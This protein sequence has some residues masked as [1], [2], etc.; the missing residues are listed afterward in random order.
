[1]ALCSSPVLYAYL[2]CSN[3]DFV[4]R[5]VTL[6][7]T[8]IDALRMCR[9]TITLLD[10]LRKRSA[11]TCRRVYASRRHASTHTHTR[12]KTPWTH[13]TAFDPPVVE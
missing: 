1:M 6:T 7:H 12:R 4:R 3:Y 9:H 8:R 5:R 13:A 2:T 10:P 11:T